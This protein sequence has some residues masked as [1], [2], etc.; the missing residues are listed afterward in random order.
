MKAGVVAA[1]ALLAGCGAAAPV[2]DRL[3]DPQTIRI[4][5][6]DGV[7]RWEPSGGAI[8]GDR[9]WVANDRGG[10]LAAY[11]LPLE[12]GRNTPV[13]AHAIAANEGRIKFEGLAPVGDGG[14]LLLET[15]KRSVWRCA[16]PEAGCPDLQRLPMDAALDRLEA[17]VP[18][19]VRY[20]TYEAIAARGDRIWVGSRGYET[21][22][23]R[24][25]PWAI[26]A[27]PHDR[28][29]YDGR[30]W[31]V[32]GRA[33]GLSDMA[34]DGDWMWMT[35]SHESPGS[36]AADVAGLIARAPIAADGTLGRPVLCYSVAGKP[37][38]IVHHGD[39]LL[40]IFDQDGDRKDPT[41][42]TRF[43]LAQDEDIVLRLPAACPDGRDKPGE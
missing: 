30:P 10:W 22:D 21:L 43:P 24:F 11:A 3:V 2:A 14:L 23:E 1:A 27:G 20:I 38:G 36:A 18:K 33:Y 37:E 42:P 29:F 15:M 17:A 8:I 7:D 5:A 9:L 41:D 34:D 28:T 4:A 31:R 26:V 39:T 40:V 13:V 19:P 12:P 32:G 16:D 35:W 6:P 25:H